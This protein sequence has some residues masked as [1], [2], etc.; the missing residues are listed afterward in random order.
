MEVASRCIDGGTLVES[1]DRSSGNTKCCSKDFGDTVSSVYSNFLNPVFVFNIC[2][3][4][5]LLLLW[6]HSK[7]H[8]LVVL[9]EVAFNVVYV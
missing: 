1:D 3:I 4:T 5:V 7:C 6:S 8:Y 2:N 9:F